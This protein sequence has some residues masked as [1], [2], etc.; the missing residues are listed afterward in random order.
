MSA[1]KSARAHARDR[2]SLDGAEP[3]ALEAALRMTDRERDEARPGRAMWPGECAPISGEF[4]PPAGIRPSEGEIS[5]FIT[6]YAE[7]RKVRDEALAMCREFEGRIRDLL[8]IDT[9][10]GS[11]A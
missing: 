2:G 7:A 3:Q 6:D 4:N 10:S 9:G 8:R 11:D 1:P 5:G